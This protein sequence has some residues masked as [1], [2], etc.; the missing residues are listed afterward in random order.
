M[1]TK[2]SC[3][4]WGWGEGWIPPPAQPPPTSLRGTSRE[5]QGLKPKIYPR[6]CFSNWKV[7]PNHQITCLIKTHTLPQ[8]VCRE[9]HSSAF[10]AGSWV[11]AVAM[12]LWITLGVS[13]KARGHGQSR[14]LSITQSVGLL[15][16]VLSPW[17][18]TPFLAFSSWEILFHLQGPLNVR[19]SWT[20]SKSPGQK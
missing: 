11:T 20:F 19:S 17:P 10:P 12:R 7:L 16:P 18:H 9:A 1:R 5:P 3:S 6:Q 15:L 4:G 8:K 14:A 2:S 13:G